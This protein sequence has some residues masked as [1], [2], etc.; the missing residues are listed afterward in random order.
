MGRASPAC[1]LRSF[2]H[3]DHVGPAAGGDPVAELGATVIDLATRM[4]AGWQT[5][6]HMRTALVT[7]ALQMAIDAGHV[8][9]DAIFHSDRGTQ[10]GFNWSSQHLDRGG[11]DGQASAL[12]EGVDGQVAD[13]VAGCAFAAA[14]CGAAVLAGD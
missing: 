1:A 12:D 5:A 8:S 13:E 9:D 2:W 7:D 11:V 14:G 4:V 3:L 6:A 10:G